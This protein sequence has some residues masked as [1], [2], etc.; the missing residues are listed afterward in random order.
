VGGVD[1]T[2][3]IGHKFGTVVWLSFKAWCL[4]L[5]I[6]A[7]CFASFVLIDGFSK[8]ATFSDILYAFVG[9]GVFFLLSL[10][11]GIIMTLPL[12]ILL[13]LI[14]YFLANQIA[15]NPKISTVMVPMF[16]TP[17][18]VGGIALVSGGHGRSIAHEAVAVPSASLTVIYAL[19]LLASAAYFSFK[20]QNQSDD[21]T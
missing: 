21:L 11:M 10:F 5:C 1:N 16:A 9:F 12:Y 14:G 20:L 3:V 17:L 8:A 13:G 15:R 7:I 18:F 4:G 6:A 2:V 19:A